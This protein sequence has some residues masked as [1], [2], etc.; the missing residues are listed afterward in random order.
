MPKSTRLFNV[1]KGQ[2]SYI[3]HINGNYC[4]DSGLP[5]KSVGWSLQGSDKMLKQVDY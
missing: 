1:S 4:K 3:K 5:A 2:S